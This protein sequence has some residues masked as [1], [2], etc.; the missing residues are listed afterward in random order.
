MPSVEAGCLILEICIIGAIEKAV[1]AARVSMHRIGVSGFF[2][3][4][5]TAAANGKSIM[6]NTDCFRHSCAAV[7]AHVAGGDGPS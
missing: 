3:K 5:T 6:R 2:P 4:G 7:G 1:R